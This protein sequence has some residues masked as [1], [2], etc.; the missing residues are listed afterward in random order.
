M[1][2]WRRGGSR[3]GKL[4]AREEGSC[5]VGVGANPHTCPSAKKRGRDWFVPAREVERYLE[6]EPGVKG[7]PRRL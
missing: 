3:K 1:Y 7:R 6:L 2:V 5:L 4:E